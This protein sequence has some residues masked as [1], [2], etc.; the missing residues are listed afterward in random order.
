MVTTQKMIDS[1]QQNSTLSIKSDYKL[2][3]VLYNLEK[4]FHFSGN[5]IWN[6]QEETITSSVP[7]SSKIL[8]M[9]TE[10]LDHDPCIKLL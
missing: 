8:I 4:D 6:S 5:G 7:N 3:F 10:E 2:S 1:Y 9:D